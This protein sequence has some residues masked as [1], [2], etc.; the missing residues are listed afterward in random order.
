MQPWMRPETNGDGSLT[1]A[2]KGLTANT[3]LTWHW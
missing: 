2:A 3:T 1:A